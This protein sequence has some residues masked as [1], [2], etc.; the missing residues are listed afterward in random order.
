MKVLEPGRPQ[1]GW[2]KAVVCTGVGNGNG[3][4]HAK[5]LVE[6]PDLYRTES[7]ARDETTTYV[8]MM[9]PCCGVETDLWNSDSPS[10]GSVPSEVRGRLKSKSPTARD[11]ARKAILEAQPS[12]S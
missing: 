4:C 3:G 1:A 10:R 9:C 2:S 8:T 6:E 11:T 12:N 5:L 7:H